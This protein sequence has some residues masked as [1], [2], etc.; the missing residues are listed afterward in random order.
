VL[1]A[2]TISFAVAILA[3]LIAELIPNSVVPDLRATLMLL[4]KSTIFDHSLIDTSFC[5]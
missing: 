5:G 4:S 3:A 2:M 1:A